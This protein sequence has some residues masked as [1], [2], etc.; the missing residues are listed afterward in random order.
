VADSIHAIV[1]SQAIQGISLIDDGQPLYCE[2][3]EYAKATRK[4]IK[5]EHQGVQASTFG[6]EIHTNVWTSPSLSLGG[7][8]YYITF[9]DD[10]SRY[11]ITRLL[12]AKSKAFQAYK[13]FA[14]WALTQHG[15]KIKRLHSDRGGE[16]IGDEFNQ[17]L[18]AQGTE[19]CA[20]T[21]HPSAQWGG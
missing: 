4:P 12:K 1:C 18:N 19:H 9:T 15:A 13:D 16:Y 2:S 7:R 17:Y 14:A 8:K 3:C 20:T 6:T 21:R 11:T 5:K 10:Y